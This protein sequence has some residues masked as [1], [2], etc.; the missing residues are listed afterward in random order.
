MSDFLSVASSVGHSNEIYFESGFFKNKILDVIDKSKSTIIVTSKSHLE[1]G[2]LDNLQKFLGSNC[3]GIVSNVQTHPTLNQIKKI[4]HEFMLNK[5]SEIIAVGGGSVIDTA[6]ILSR[7]LSIYNL[8][9]LDKLSENNISSQVIRKVGITAVPTTSG[10]GSEVTPFATLWNFEKREKYSIFGEDLRPD[11]AILDSSLTYSLPIDKTLESG[12]DAIS[13]AF[14]SLWNLNST[15]ETSKI[16][17]A[18][19]ELSLNNLVKLN[20]NLGDSEAR[21]NM[22]KSSLLAGLAISKTRTSIS[23]SISY[24]ITA[25]LRVPHGIACAISLPTLIKLTSGLNPEL[26][27]E[28][29]NELNFDTNNE[30]SDFVFNLLIEIGVIEKFKT[31][32]QSPDRLLRLV[33]NMLDND[34]SGNFLLDFDLDD[35]GIEVIT[36]LIDQIFG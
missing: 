29:K 22:M 25:S 30:L 15:I 35:L 32:V 24:P 5:P 1:R 20:N 28:L 23:H 18:S 27:N 3:L 12:L 7:L 17:Q 4:A 6:K 9:G 31:L 14:D 10:T 21:D 34:R 26:F 13:H 11:T 8:E 36:P 33:P 19:L 16:S 2:T